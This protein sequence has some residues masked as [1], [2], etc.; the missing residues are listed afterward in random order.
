MSQSLWS[1]WEMRMLLIHRS[2]SRYQATKTNLLSF[3]CE[4]WLWTAWT[5][6][7]SKP[8]VHWWWIQR[9]NKIV[10]FSQWGLLW[11][12]L[13]LNLH[14]RHEEAVTRVLLHTFYNRVVNRV[15]RVVIH[16]NDTDVTSTFPGSRRLTD[17]SEMLVRTAQ[18]QNIPTLLVKKTCRCINI[19]HYHSDTRTHHG[20][21]QHQSRP[22]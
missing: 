5:L 1:Q 19:W 22:V 4:R 15:D 8:S 17:L 3:P 10:L 16:I 21:V 6:A 12:F 9:I 7:W 18:N 20:C 11:R 13:P 2:F 14:N